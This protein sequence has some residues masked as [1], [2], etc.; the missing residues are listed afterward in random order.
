MDRLWDR[1]FE[2]KGLGC[3]QPTTQRRLEP[4]HRPTRHRH[5]R[6]PHTRSQPF[7]PAC[8]HDVGRLESQRERSESLDGVHHEQG[9]T[10][11]VPHRL[12]VSPEAGQIVDRAE[13]DGRG[14]RIDIRPEDIGD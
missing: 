12:E 10:S 2:S 4:F 11:E 8:D 7:L 3:P 14:V 1:K 9:I 13:G 6:H 5:Y